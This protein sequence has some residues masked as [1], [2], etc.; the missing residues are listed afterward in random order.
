MTCAKGKEQHEKR[1]SQADPGC[2]TSVKTTRRSQP[3]HLFR[4]TGFAI[5]RCT[6]AAPAQSERGFQT[7]QTHGSETLWRRTALEAMR[8][9][10]RDRCWM[11]MPSSP[12]QPCARPYLGSAPKSMA[13]P[14]ES[15]VT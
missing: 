5:T 1:L 12:S 3:L 15:D 2:L 7:P 8:Y 10:R 11:Q 9:G 4:Q 6:R 14:C 13:L